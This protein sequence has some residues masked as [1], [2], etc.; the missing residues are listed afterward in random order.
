M[1]KFSK[2]CLITSLILI[3]IGG[4]ISVI[5]AISGGWRLVREIEG[6]DRWWQMIEDVSDG[7][8]AEME[9]SP[10]KQENQE[11]EKLKD[12]TVKTVNDLEIDIGGAALYVRES[13]DG[14]FGF[15]AD[16]KGKY[17][18]Y[19]SGGVLYV[20]GAENHL[21]INNI[22]NVERLYLDI[23]KGMTF[24]AV[25]VS[26][27]A[28]LVEMTAIDADEIE[29]MIGA[30]KIDVDG[31]TGRS[32]R[33]E[34]GA[35]QASIKGVEVEELDVEVGLGDSYVQGSVTEEIDIECG[36]GRS[37]LV[38][39]DEEEDF[40]YDISCA[41][42]SVSIGGRSYSALADDTYIDNEAS[43]ECSMECAMGTIEIEFE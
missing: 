6:N 21:M 40:N 5:G 22:D 11:T 41:A 12:V 43:R 35:G 38:L 42:G 32:L 9:G 27:G 33:V 26:V 28:G 8:W 1:R 19:E 16:G 2:I 10:T 18:C 36:M 39:T 25:T 30:G 4:T 24:G 20:E 23:P 13:K 3:L 15:H 34:T 29:L 14:T 17:K 31:I 7:H 37:Q